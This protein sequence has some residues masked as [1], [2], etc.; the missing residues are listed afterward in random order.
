MTGRLSSRSMFLA[1]GVTVAGMV[2]ASCAAGSSSAA[3]QESVS[4]NASQTEYQ[5]ALAGLDPV[6]LTMQLPAGPGTVTSAPAEAYAAA[7]EKWSGGKIGFDILYSGSR[8]PTNEMNEAL[9]D[10]LVDIGMHMPVSAPEAFPAS[11]L[12]GDLMFLQEPTPLLGS[13]QLVSSWMEFGVEQKEITREVLDHG[14]QPLLPLLPT[15]G[16]S[17]LCAKEPVTSL[18]ETKGKQIRA[19]APSN[20]PALE[21]L[22]ATV[23]SLPIAEVYQG[24]QRGVV[25]C[26]S[27]TP[28]A[29][30][31]M[32]LF[33]VTS[34]WTLDPE[35]Q[36]PA[37]PMAFGISKPTW[38]GLPLAARQLLWDRLDVFVE[39]QLSDATF[40][41][42][43]EA[44]AGA[45]KHGVRIHKWAPDA[46]EALKAHQDQVL[47]E[48]SDLAPDGVDGQ[49][50]VAA[51]KETSARWRSILTQ[52]LGLKDEATW[53][54]FGQWLTDN[55]LD[56]GPLADKL[57]TEVIAPNRPVS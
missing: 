1:G 4:A 19:S 21:A 9:A 57:V 36:L 49:A 56:A 32:G 6:T 51:A 35:V 29:I 42:I 38:D 27:T 7:V 30:N 46:R 47:D 24:M 16:V 22:G 54:E 11:T 8:V 23:V 41:Q 3:S 12:A 37:S 34:D 13:M 10:G 25:D 28:S 52:D 20:G 48:A 33:E 44:L 45:A 43:G 50:F 14:I 17:L 15:S 2:L 18:S 40:A 55:A 26:A 31:P 53:D 5:A 39:K